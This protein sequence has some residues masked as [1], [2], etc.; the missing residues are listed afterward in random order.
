MTSTRSGTT[1]TH[2]PASFLQMVRSIP[3]AAR[4]VWRGKQAAW[5]ASSLLRHPLRD[6]GWNSDTAA[7]LHAEVERLLPGTGGIS[8]SR[9]I[10]A[11]STLVCE[12]DCIIL[13]DIKTLTQQHNRSNV[14]RTSAYL[15]CYEQYPELHWALLAHMVS[16]NGGYHMTDLH[17]DLMHNLQNQ[18]DREH[19]YRLLE[20]CNALIFQDAYP[21]LQ[22]YIHSRRLGRS[23]FHLLSHFHV[24][25]FMTPFWERFWLERCSSILSVALIINEQNYIESRVVQHPYFQKGVLSKP[26][27]HL[28]NLAGLNHIVFPL[29]QG[30]GLTGRVIEHFGKINER[31]QFG[32]SLYALLFGVEQVLQQ[33]LEFA[34]AIPHRGSRAEY[35]P[36]LFTTHH[37]GPQDHKLYAEAL[38]NE[39]WLPEGQRLYSPELLAV[40]GDTPYEPIT[41]QDWL[42]T[43]DCLGYLTAP[44]RPWLFEMSH[45]HRYGMLKTALAHDVQQIT[46]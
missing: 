39:E 20:R 5:Q 23:C 28:H 37:A 31:I 33:V 6:L 14:T 11:N 42:Q 22:L 38:L 9:S 21:Q 46:H 17:S 34:R 10:Q 36:G 44:R 12:E 2:H 18:Q 13:E 45:E 8:P 7:A 30:A 15:E 25:A 40:W 1:E 19:M 32:K 3:G 29:G 26:A 43:R 27:F 35:W 41:R 16:R 4:E 24:S